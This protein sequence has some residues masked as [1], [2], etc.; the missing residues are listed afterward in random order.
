MIR[1][2]NI[3]PTNFDKENLFEE[4]KIFLIYLMAHIPEI[5]QW[6][7]N[8]E[9][10]TRLAEIKQL[11]TITLTETEIDMA[12]IND[13]PLSQVKKEKLFTEKKKRINELNKEFG[14]VAEEREV[15]KVVETNTSANYSNPERLWDLLQGKGLVK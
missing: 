1:H 11:E 14:I 7:R 13:Q 9:Y 6:K 8:V 3:F 4:Q 12:S 5:D 15:E 2:F 10:K